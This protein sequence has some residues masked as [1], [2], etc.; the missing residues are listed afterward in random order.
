MVTLRLQE[1]AQERAWH[2][3]SKVSGISKAD[4]ETYA[5]EKISADLQKITE[6][7]GVSSITPSV[8]DLVKGK[9][10]YLL[11]KASGVSEEM[12]QNYITKPVEVKNAKVANDL[13]K[14]ADVLNVPI[15]N[16]IEPINSL[17]AVS[18]KILQKARE[19]FTPSGEGFT[20]NHILLEKL[21]EKSGV[22]ITLLVF[23]ATQ[24]IKKDKLSEPEILKDI[25]RISE[26]LEC[27][28][29]ELQEPATLPITKLDI[30]SLSSQIGL[31]LEDLALLSDFPLQF[32]NLIATHPLDKSLFEHSAVDGLICDWFC[33]IFPFC[34]ERRNTP[35]WS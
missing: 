14:I 29:K 34:C 20:E 5:T 27:T 15:P 22:H 31:T 30:E 19:K 6:A 23:Y 32:I 26:V 9:T 3:L 13:R 21:R 33:S 28:I 1:L 10:L 8:H 4:I 25:K 17:E 12:L 2:L 11:S 7:L 24:A 35:S 18:L 16:L